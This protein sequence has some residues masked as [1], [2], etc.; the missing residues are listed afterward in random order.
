MQ[1][2]LAIA[3]HCSLKRLTVTSRESLSSLSRPKV[4]QVALEG[5]F[6]RETRGCQGSSLLSQSPSSQNL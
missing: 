3:Q 6:P 5:P 4:T 2:V 1:T